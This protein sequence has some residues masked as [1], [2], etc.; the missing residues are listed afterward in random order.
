MLPVE[1]AP[2][3]EPASAGIEIRVSTG[4]VV[5]FESGTDVAYVARLVA[6]LRSGAC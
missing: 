3:S 2:A 5:A 4:D 1:L 6:A